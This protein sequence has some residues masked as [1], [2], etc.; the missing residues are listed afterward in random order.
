MSNPKVITRFAPSPTGLLHIGAVRTAL[1]SYLYAKQNSGDFILRIE[2]T[3]TE[4]NKPEYEQEII[5]DFDWLA[6]NYG[7]T[8]YRQS[9]RKDLYEKYL[10][11]LIKDGF[12]YI[13]KEEPTI[14]DPSKEPRRS[15]VIRF[16]NPNKKV[17]FSD[18]IRGDVTF[19]TTD[20]G[21]FVIAKSLTE[22]LYHLAVVVDDFEM[23]VTHVIRAEE[24]ISNTP[25]QI[26]I[27]QAIGAPQPIYAHLPLIL[28]TE[29]AK[30][31][32]R[33]HGEQ[34]S[35]LYYIKQGYLRD[36]IINYLALL[37][38]NPGTEQE[39]FTF[40]ELVKVFDISK[41]QKSGAI[42]DPEK[43]RWINKQHMERLPKAELYTRIKETF[44]DF[45]IAGDLLE[46][47]APVVLERISAFGELK[48]MAKQGEFDYAFKS[49][50]YQKEA[51]LW[52]GKGDFAILKNRLHSVT[53]LLE[54]IGTN[55][56]NKETAKAAIWDY[57]TA[58]GRGEVLWP[59]R[60][61]LS[62]KEK[63][64]DPFVLA[65]LVGKT[66]TLHRLK[67]AIEKIS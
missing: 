31:S 50:E 60:Y 1:F 22:P 11:K 43:L 13:S 47:L 3:D 46:K 55:E 17:M 18:L 61:A 37:G 7:G 27:Q 10:A 9:E 38:W 49:P 39:I 56:F 28:D 32:K 57:A 15:E 59:M 66:E 36:G 8:F 24:H 26:L 64:P 45:D 16:K 14:P 20:L 21:D 5:S 42:F 23:K 30:L 52:K 54:K 12:A 34:V 4:R 67:L 62:G 33:K 2:D 48:E 53:Q 19:D 58:E 51:L 35:L 65:E 25:R 40:D 6:F 63:S 41:V 44:N 29:R